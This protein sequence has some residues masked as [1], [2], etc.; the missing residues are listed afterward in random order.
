MTTSAIYNRLPGAGVGTNK[1]RFAQ[2]F[3]RMQRHFEHDYNFVPLTFDL[4]YEADSLKRHMNAHKGKKT[5]ILKPHNGAEGCGILLV[6]QYKQIPA[7]TFAQGYI[8]QEYLSNP[9]LL[10]GK[11]FDLR[12]YVMVT[13]IGSYPEKQPVAFIADEGLV[14]LCTEDYARPDASN[15]HNL[16]SHLTNFSLNKL[17]DKFVNSED[18]DAYNIEQSSK[19]PLSTVLNQLKEEQEV[20][21][22]FLFDQISEACE[23]S[24][25]AMQPYSLIEQEFQF[26]GRWNERK[27]DCFQI[28]GFDIFI[29]SNLKV[30]VLEINDHPS[31]NILLCKEGPTSLLKFPSEVDKFIK[32]K[33]VGDAIK[34]MRKKKFRQDRTQLP[35]HGCWRR[36]LPSGEE[37]DYQTFA[38]AKYLYER[39][40]NR[41][42]VRNMTLTCFGKL[43]KTK[44]LKA[45]ITRV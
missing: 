13:Q 27:G 36:I 8:A 7:H 35:E 18:L 25:L 33:V 12:I 3:K 39:L 15:L 44:T 34:L 37:E 11:K 20:D 42:G 2:I 29:D 38:K 6:Q 43:C 45:K 9:L 24:L 14:R 30:W 1:A 40:L 21:T 28:L 31:L 23:K 26:G 19:R 16:L 32:T 4:S 17:S 5:Y 41:K 10:D 22:D